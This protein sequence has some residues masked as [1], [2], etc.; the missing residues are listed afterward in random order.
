MEGVR[1]DPE[2]KSAAIAA[3][4]D[5]PEEEDQTSLGDY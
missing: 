1:E 4:A 5:D 2:A 3:E